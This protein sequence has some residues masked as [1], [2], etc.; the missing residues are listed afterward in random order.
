MTDKDRAIRPEEDAAER[1]NAAVTERIRLDHEHDAS[2][3]TPAELEANASLRTADE[4]VAARKRWL[5]WV[6]E[7]S[8]HEPDAPAPAPEAVQ[9]ENGE[10]SDNRRRRPLVDLVIKRQRLM[11]G[12]GRRA[13]RFGSSRHS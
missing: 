8:A 5:R 3:G 13:K 4:N 12:V 10:A 11:R 7:P 1:L 6:Q 2:R 9:D